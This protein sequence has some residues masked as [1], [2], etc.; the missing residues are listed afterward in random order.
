MFG[1]LIELICCLTATAVVEYDERQY[2]LNI[3]DIPF[4]I[5]Y[6]TGVAKESYILLIA[7]FREYKRLPRP[8]ETY[9]KRNL[10]KWVEGLKKLQNSGKLPIHGIRALAYV[11]TYR[12]PNDP[13][14]NLVLRCPN[15]VA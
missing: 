4:E 6:H 14:Y 3:Q 8:N 15:S 7:F 10:G 11:D 5:M 12:S 1:F 9:R 2:L 13:F